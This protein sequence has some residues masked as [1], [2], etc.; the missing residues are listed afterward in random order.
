M[1]N[2]DPRAQHVIDAFLKKVKRSD[3]NALTGKQSEQLNMA[4]QHVLL[5][6]DP[7]TAP[8]T[9]GGDAM[10]DFMDRERA[11]GRTRGLD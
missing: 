2:R 3:V 4:I 6:N 8:R 5:A 7:I 1:K 9:Y 10:R 11:A